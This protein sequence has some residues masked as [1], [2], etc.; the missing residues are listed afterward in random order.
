MKSEV[1]IKKELQLLKRKR[2]K[3][4]KRYVG[5]C[6][7]CE[8]PGERASLLRAEYEVLALMQAL[9]WVLHDGYIMRPLSY[10]KVKGV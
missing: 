9:D 6:P 10:T 4:A 8:A 1:T 2:D 7:E 5:L 3:I